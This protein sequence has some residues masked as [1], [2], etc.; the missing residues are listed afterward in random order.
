L[1]PELEYS[2]ET[3]IN[4]LDET[5][6]NVAI[7]DAQTKA[8]IHDHVVAFAETMIETIS[9]EYDLTSHLIEEDDETG[10]KESSSVNKTKK[11]LD[12]LATMKFI[13]SGI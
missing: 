1:I 8:E 6:I 3:E 12:L 4:A 5:A 10:E 7:R 13:S 2:T 11:S 9:N